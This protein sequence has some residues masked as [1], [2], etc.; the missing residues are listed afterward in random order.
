MQSRA[1]PPLPRQE[2]A[3]TFLHFAFAF[4]QVPSPISD[5]HLSTTNERGE[6]EGTNE[7]ERHFQRLS[8]LSIG[9]HE[10]LPLHHL[11]TTT[12]TTSRPVT[13]TDR[14]SFSSSSSS[15]SHHHLSFILILRRL[16]AARMH[17]L[18][19]RSLARAI[20]SIIS[21]RNR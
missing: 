12:I 13:T 9:S 2:S 5:A 16:M 3:G 21:E 11:T 1:P 6:N 15:S 4:M 7:R 14:S 10:A 17:N 19:T 18:A 20:I 8:I